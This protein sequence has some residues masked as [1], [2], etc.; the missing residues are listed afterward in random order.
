MVERV[1]GIELGLHVIRPEGHLI[2][3]PGDAV[4]AAS[5]GIALAA[6]ISDADDVVVPAQ[7]HGH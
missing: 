2:S 7:A 4:P 3:R 5:E 6:G 1:A